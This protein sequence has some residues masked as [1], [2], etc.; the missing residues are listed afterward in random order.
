MKTYDPS[1]LPKKITVGGKIFSVCSFRF[2]GKK[3]ARHKRPTKSKIVMIN[4]VKFL[5][6]DTGH[7]LVPVESY[8]KDVYND[9]IQRK[10][11]GVY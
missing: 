3:I 9:F 5:L 10:E 1:E 8:R 6:T 4:G 7:A 11:T 2:W